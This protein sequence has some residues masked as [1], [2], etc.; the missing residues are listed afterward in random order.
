MQVGYIHKWEQIAPLFFLKY[1]YAVKP[2]NPNPDQRILD[3]MEKQNKAFLEEF[4]VWLHH[5]DCNSE[6]KCASDG[7]LKF[8]MNLEFI[9][10]LLVNCT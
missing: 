2:P 6:Q 9:S 3:I 1:C 8:T 7:R 4:E 5:G 10:Y